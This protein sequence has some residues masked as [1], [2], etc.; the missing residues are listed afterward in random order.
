M[1][2]IKDDKSLADAIAALQN[3]QHSELNL[4]KSHLDFTL[5]SLNPINIIK[6]KFS[7]FDKSPVQKSETIKEIV[8]IGTNLIGSRLLFGGKLNPLNKILPTLIQ[9]GVNGFLTKNPEIT[10]FS[11]KKF[12]KNVLSKMKIKN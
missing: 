3:Q 12:L 4:L 8:E 5:D 9:K 1:Q 2:T 7:F 10:E 6:E 11:S